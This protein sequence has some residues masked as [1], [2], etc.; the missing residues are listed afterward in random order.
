MGVV[1]VLLENNGV[2]YLERGCALFAID[3]SPEGLQDGQFGC[4]CVDTLTGDLYQKKSAIGTLTGWTIVG[5]SGGSGTVASGVT[6]RIA[7]YPAN[8][9]TIDDA[10]G[11]EYVGTSP[12]LRITGLNPSDNVLHL[13]DGS[14][15]TPDSGASSVVAILQVDAETNYHMALR[16]LAA[17]V[18]W[19]NYV[20][21]DGNLYYGAYDTGNATYP[22][23]FIY[24]IDGVL[25]FSNQILASPTSG[26]IG[27]ISQNFYGLGVNGG[28]D[29]WLITWNDEGATQPIP[30][31]SFIDA[32]IGNARLHLFQDATPTNP[33]AYARIKDGSGNAYTRFL[34]PY[35]PTLQNSADIIPASPSIYDD[36]FDAGSLDGKWS[37]LNIGTSTITFP[38]FSYATFNPQ[39]SNARGYVQTVPVGN[40]TATLKLSSALGLLT[41]SDSWA[42]LWIHTSPDGTGYGLE[43]GR[44]SA[45][46]YQVRCERLSGYN[47]NGNEVNGITWGFPIAYLRFVYTGGNLQCYVSADGIAFS[48]FGSAFAATPTKFGFFARDGAANAAFFDWFRV[49]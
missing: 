1:N 44:N 49:T 10:I 47:F 30:E 32:D 19:L 39:A 29:N 27:Q 34:P 13:S 41:G 21:D 5:G 37:A 31:T 11:V 16:N 46:A 23:L 8:G 26:L 15:V 22:N 33:I 20:A 3:G 18:D 2:F 43:I 36:E 12:M 17:Q 6:P 38:Q 14:P 45:D 28:A 40:F 7:Y 35:N 48:P 24:R 25:T 9:T 4:L 42:G